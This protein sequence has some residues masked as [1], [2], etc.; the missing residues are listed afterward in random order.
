MLGGRRALPHAPAD[1]CCQSPV[2]SC[3]GRRN[4]QRCIRSSRTRRHRHCASAKYRREPRPA[5]GRE[6]TIP[7][8]EARAGAVRNRGKPL[9]FQDCRAAR[10]LAC[11]RRCVTRFPVAGRAAERTGRSR[12]HGDRVESNRIRG[13]W[14][15]RPHTDF[16]ASAERAEFPGAGPAAARRHR[17]LGDEPRCLWQQLPAGAHERRL[18][19]ADAHVGGWID[20]GR[21]LR[22]RNHAGVLAGVGRGVQ[23]LDLQSG[24]G[25]GCRRLRRDQCCDST[26]NEHHQRRRV[27]LLSQP[28]SGGVPRVATPAWCAVARLR[29]PADRGQRRRSAGP[30]PGVLVRQLRAQRS[31]RGVCREQQPSDLLQVRWY[32]PQPA[33]IESRKHQTGRPRVRPAP[34]LVS[35]QHRSQ[36]H[37]RSSGGGGHALE[38][39]IRRQQSV[40]NP[41]RRHVHP[42]R[43]HDQRVA[44]VL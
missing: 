41:D 26:R 43:K 29:P 39:A 21:P 44:G 7:A 31:G 28:G 1:R 22:R 24:P 2:S 20:R 4:R 40:P 16:R 38:L 32:L 6:W 42:H 33:H 30:R 9:R 27:P 10:D 12:E 19:L 35:S 8:R 18:L 36:S 3:G 23:G 17:R 14:V 13:W 11:R 25:D 15:R 37:E 5:D 34:G